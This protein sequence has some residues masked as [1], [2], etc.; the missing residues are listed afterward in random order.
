MEKGRRRVLLWGIGDLH[1][2]PRYGEIRVPLSEEWF[3]ERG[4][5]GPVVLD[6]GI[7]IQESQISVENWFL[8]GSRLWLLVVGAGESL[9]GVGRGGTIYHCETRSGPCRCHHGQQL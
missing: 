6:Q 2:A 8:H 4:A 1:D 7:D 9:Y 5:G 3:V